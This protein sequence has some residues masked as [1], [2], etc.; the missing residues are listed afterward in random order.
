MQEHANYA[1]EATQIEFFMIPPQ[2]KNAN[3][4]NFVLAVPLKI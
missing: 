1:K 2:Y 3:I 4:A